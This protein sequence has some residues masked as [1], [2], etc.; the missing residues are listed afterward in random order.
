MHSDRGQIHLSVGLRVARIAIEEAMLFMAEVAGNKARG[1]LNVVCSAR[2]MAGKATARCKR[3][4]AFR[5]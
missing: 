4:A 1:W 3:T 5:R 2:L